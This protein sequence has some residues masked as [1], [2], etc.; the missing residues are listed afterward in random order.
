M[1]A[2]QKK[3]ARELI[4]RTQLACGLGIA[5]VD[6]IDRGKAGHSIEEKKATDGATVLPVVDLLA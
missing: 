2:V 1:R 4:P 6:V 3:C 5:A